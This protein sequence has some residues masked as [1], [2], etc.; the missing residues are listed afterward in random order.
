MAKKKPAQ[1]K[2]ARTSAA[3]R[4]KH[5]NS[6]ET[7]R[8]LE[9]AV[10]E[11]DTSAI[12]R[13][14]AARLRAGYADDGKRNVS[15]DDIIA[16]AE[17]R[18]DSEE[19]KKAFDDF[20]S[21]VSQGTIGAAKL[22]TAADMIEDE[23]LLLELVRKGFLE[24]LQ[25]HTMRRRIADEARDALEEVANNQAAVGW[26]SPDDR[27]P[28]AWTVAEFGEAI[29]VNGTLLNDDDRVPEKPAN[30]V[31][32]NRGGRVPT[33]EEI[34]HP[35]AISGAVLR[36]LGVSVSGA[37]KIVVDILSEDN[38]H[39]IPTSV[40]GETEVWMSETSAKDERVGFAEEADFDLSVAEDRR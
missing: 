13:L 5:R 8:A 23:E 30:Y 22:V 7:I 21:S 9:R 12:A 27:W 39:G 19:A 36:G 26:S 33:T 18:L 29:A 28:D 34:V 11:G 20:I 3:R 38:Q 16:L 4:P 1:K 24:A 32:T 37:D 6:D 2:P 31:L 17:Q 40:S 15:V 25:S 35:T 14:A 10:A